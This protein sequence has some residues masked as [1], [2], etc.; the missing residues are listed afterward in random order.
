[1]GL[2]LLSPPST[3]TDGS[4]VGGKGDPIRVEKFSIV[5]DHYNIDRYI[6]TTPYPSIWGMWCDNVR[7]SQIKRI[8]LKFILDRL[9]LN[10]T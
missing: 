3:P 10:I 4:G 5:F 9:F 7:L 6:G 8:V 2:H 1:M